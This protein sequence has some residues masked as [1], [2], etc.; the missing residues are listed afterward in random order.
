MAHASID[1]WFHMEVES[2]KQKFAEQTRLKKAQAAAAA[3]QRLAKMH[4]EGQQFLDEL[5]L[6][7]LGGAARRLSS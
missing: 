2:S 6:K 4:Y 5:E 3:E 7:A 1:G